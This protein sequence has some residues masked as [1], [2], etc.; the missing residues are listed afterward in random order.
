MHADIISVP[1]P[2]VNNRQLRSNLF[3][4]PLLFI[5]FTVESSA[6]HERLQVLSGVI[7]GELISLFPSYVYICEK[8]VSPGVSISILRIVPV[9]DSV[10]KSVV[11]SFPPKARFVVVLPSVHVLSL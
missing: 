4:K 7:D 11:R 1:L 6:P 8:R 3:L 10:M 2:K 5:L 9:A